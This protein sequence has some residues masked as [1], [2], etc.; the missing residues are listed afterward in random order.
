MTKAN[1]YDVIFTALKHPLRRRILLLLDEKGEV[2]FTDIQK[3]VGLEDTGLM[4]YHLRELELLVSQSA[5]GRYRLSEIGRISVALLKKVERSRG[6][7][8]V[9][10]KEL[11]RVVGEVLWFLVIAAVPWVVAVSVDIYF[12]VQLIYNTGNTLVAG[13]YALSLLTMYGGVALFTVYD[14]HYFSKLVRK[15]ILHSMLFALSI[16]LILIPSE[17]MTYQFMVKTIPTQHSSAE[18]FYGLVMLLRIILFAVGSPFITYLTCKLVEFSF[19]R[20]T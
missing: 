2:S 19:K 3:T 1:E 13:V 14:R 17:Y 8:K 11:G 15:N 16:I 5:R 9:V 10:R 6:V 20:K 4:S 12:S 7:S 18:A